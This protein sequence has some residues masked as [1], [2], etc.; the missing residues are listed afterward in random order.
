M[1]R[2]SIKYKELSK[3]QI[4]ESRNVVISECSKGGF[5]MAQQLEVQEGNS[6]T[7]VFLKGALKLD[8]I[9]CL[10]NLRDAVNLAIQRAET[11]D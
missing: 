9:D 2:D 11:A 6:T 5:T 10:Y 7:T 3:A 4:N 1:M 8:N